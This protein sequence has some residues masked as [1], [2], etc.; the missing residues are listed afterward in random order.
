VAV[1][2]DGLN[3]SCRELLIQYLPELSVDI[4]EHWISE[5]KIK[6]RITRHRRSKSGDY[7]CPQYRNE[8]NISINRDLNKYSFLITFIHEYAHLLV[9]EKFRNKVKPHGKE[10]KAEY[11]KL[12]NQFLDNGIFPE[13]IN[14]L[15]KKTISHTKAATSGYISLLRCLAEYDEP[16]DTVSVESIPVNSDFK[17]PD[18]RIFR[19][20]Q[21]LRRRYKCFCYNNRRI[22]SFHPLAAVFPVNK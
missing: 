11:G 2:S 10:W 12:A 4:V 20:E 22:Y 7:R 21:K 6:L 13:K 8:H 17:L 16:K 9:W 1:R 5:K 15:L 14:E 18:G 19:M 3:S